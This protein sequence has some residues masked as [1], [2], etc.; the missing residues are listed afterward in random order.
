MPWVQPPKKKE[1]QRGIFAPA[2]T[3]VYRKTS[4]KDFFSNL[5]AQLCPGHCG[6]CRIIGSA[7]TK[8]KDDVG[9]EL[10]GEEH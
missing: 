7:E 3:E 9:K 6:A 1:S 2:L 5:S 10:Y 4:N 8:P